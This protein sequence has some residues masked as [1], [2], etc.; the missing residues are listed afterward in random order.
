MKKLANKRQLV[1]EFFPDQLC[2]FP[3]K[4]FYKTTNTILSAYQITPEKKKRNENFFIVILQILNIIMNSK[5]SFTVDF[6]FFNFHRVVKFSIPNKFHL[7]TMKK[8]SGNKVV[9]YYNALLAYCSLLKRN[10]CKGCQM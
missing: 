1:G 5:A 2:I 4:Y 10:L 9:I 7:E 6:I 3:G 8:E